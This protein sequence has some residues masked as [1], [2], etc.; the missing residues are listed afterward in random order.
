MIRS[1]TANPSK[2][3][4]DNGLVG[5]LGVCLRR[6][7]LRYFSRYS[8]FSVCPTKEGRSDC[9]FIDARGARQLVPIQKTGLEYM[10]R[11]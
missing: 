5:Y 9:S 8:R 10:Y 3:A 2:Q 1:R 7:V 4:I 11:Q 6:K